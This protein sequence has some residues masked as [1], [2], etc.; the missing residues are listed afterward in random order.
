MAAH[1]NVVVC[2]VLPSDGQ[3]RSR[4]L[5]IH[6]FAGVMP[7]SLKSN[8]ARLAGFF[9]Q[10]RIR[11]FVAN[12]AWLTGDRVLRTAVGAV[13]T[14]LMV[15]Q[16]GPEQFGTLAFCGSLLAMLGPF[17]GLGLELILIRELV[18]AAACRAELLPTV[19]ILK[20]LGIAFVTAAGMA[21]TYLLRPD[22][23]NSLTITAIL[24]IGLLGQACDVFDLW[25][26]AILHN[27][28]AVLCRNAAFLVFAIIKIILVIASASL[29]SFAAAIAGETLL[30]AI[31]LCVFGLKSAGAV[32]FRKASAA[33]ARRLLVEAF[34]FIA[35]AFCVSAYM[36]ADT[37]LIAAIVDD[38]AVGIYAAAVR[39]SEIWYLLPTAVMTSVFPFVAARTDADD[40][41]AVEIRTA[42]YGVLFWI[43]VCAALVFTFSSTQL[44]S[45]LFGPKYRDAS[46]VLA[47]NSWSAIPVFLGVASSQH[48][49][50][51]RLSKYS[52]YRTFIGLV[53]NIA[54]NATLIS[55]WGVFGAAVGTTVSYFAA[56]YSLLLFKATRQHAILMCTAP[57]K[58]LHFVH[59]TGQHGVR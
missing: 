1:G 13:V 26:Q 51:E 46:A 53:V 24:C 42:I 8:A 10:S 44:I 3:A 23:L 18:R 12:A 32:D 37:V 43:A 22:D 4:C 31:L 50:S 52:L 34:P 55:L 49:V 19:I 39:I 21:F 20:L 35:A 17:I 41:R 30:A 27:R 6:V 47:V 54:L 38:T 16:L 33:C 48:L 2:W 29:I 59:T 25:F 45:I 40:L 58:V 56:T 11:E 14:V 28:T 57:F 7:Y 9:V 15:R 5:N 36:R